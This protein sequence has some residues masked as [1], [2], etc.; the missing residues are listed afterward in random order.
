MARTR[1][2]LRKDASNPVP[3]KTPTNK[4]LPSGVAEGGI[5]VHM[6]EREFGQTKNDGMHMHVFRLPDGQF[7]AT[8]ER[9]QHKHTFSRDEP[10]NEIWHGGEHY[11]TIRF[12]DGTELQ[13]ELDGWHQHDMQTDSTAFDG[14]HCH[15]L[16]LP[17]GS[18]IESLTPADHYLL[19]GQQPQSNQPMGLPASALAKEHGE[20][21][22][23]VFLNPAGDLELCFGD[24]AVLRLKIGRG[25]EATNAELLNVETGS[26]SNH[27]LRNVA[28][29]WSGSWDPGGVDLG[30]ATIEVGLLTPEQHEYFLRLPSSIPSGAGTLKVSKMGDGWVATLTKSQLPEVLMSTDAPLLLGTPSIPASLRADV[31]EAVQY[32]KAK[33]IEEARRQRDWLVEVGHFTAEH[34]VFQVGKSL[35]RVEVQKGFWLSADDTP[36]NIADLFPDNIAELVVFETRKSDDDEDVMTV[37]AAVEEASTCG[38]DW[39]VVAKDTKESRDKM[40][41]LGTPFKTRD[42]RHSDFLFLTSFYVPTTKV[43]YVS[44]TVPREPEN[45]TKANTDEWVEIVQRREK[46][47]DAV[48]GLLAKARV[49]AKKDDEEERFVYGVVMEP[50]ETDT[51]GDTQDATEIRQAAHKFLEDFG[52]IGLQHQTFVTGRVKILESFIAPEGFSINGHTVK[53]GSWI[54]GVRVLDDVLWKAVKDGSLTGFSIGGKAVREPIA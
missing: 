44:P 8:D 5:H 35:R 11:H 38:D 43:A 18:V 41:S 20:I 4:S 2:R 15:R 25:E 45:T 9:G 39:L 52:N 37:D 28:A 34:E 27:A 32:W 16:R 7:V 42:W 36:V 23:D 14:L 48:D 46:A 53:K 17:D 29:E 22:A 30:K 51:Q 26:P 6:L 13:T 50:D 3:A 31:P 40:A 47:R 10:S 19:E 21:K 33:T 54:M 1:V 12:E 24:D 49:I